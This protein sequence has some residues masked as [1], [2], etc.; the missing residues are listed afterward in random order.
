MR[1]RLYKGRPYSCVCAFDCC[2]M[3]PPCDPQVLS[4]GPS[5]RLPRMASPLILTCYVV[6]TVRIMLFREDFR[7]FSPRQPSF[8]SSGSFSVSFARPRRAVGVVGLRRTNG[9]H[10]G[11][12]GQ[13]AGKTSS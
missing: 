7:R 12:E 8:V 4:L 9:N 10:E 13:T 5:R 11:H 6:L 1:M 3:E 2:A